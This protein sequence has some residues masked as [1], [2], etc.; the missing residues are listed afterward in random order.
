MKC[1]DIQKM[2]G[3]EKISM[4]TCYDYSFSKA[5]AGCVDILLVGDS[6]GNVVLGL[7]KTNKV[8]MEDMLRHVDAVRR[9]S[10]EGFI[11]CDLPYGAYE[12]GKEAVIH[13]KKLIAA[14]ADALKPEGKPEIVKALTDNG[15]DVMGHIGYLPQTQKVR[16]HK[17]NEL[18]DIAKEIESAGAFA[19]V[20]EMV[21]KELASRITQELRIPTIGIGSGKECDGQVLVLYDLLGLFPDFEPRF[22]RKYM[23]LKTDIRKAVEKYTNDVK[24]GSFPG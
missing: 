19:I 1:Q 15:V 9:G 16:M 3:K 2:K 10:K 21:D 7:D 24:K 4:V 20:L 8:T 23:N 17:E 11:V 13:A 18:I 12:T 14:G 22:V 6:L 5:I